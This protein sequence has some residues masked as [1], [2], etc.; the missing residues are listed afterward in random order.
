V[1][2]TQFHSLVLKLG[3][4]TIPETVHAL[5]GL[6]AKYDATHP[7]DGVFLSQYLNDLYADIERQ[8]TIFSAFSGVAIAIAALGLLGL[9]ISTAERRTKEIGLRKVLGAKRLDILQFL[10]WQFARPVLW[11]NFLAWPCAYFVL[12]RWLEGFAYHIDQGPLLFILAGALALL[13][14]FL[15]VVGH[16]L[17]VARAKPVDALRYE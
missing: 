12:Q 5:E 17:A 1:D 6:W 10:A 15:T 3:G 7:F 13:I 16:A 14:A 11:A 2:P 9:A 4:G 8:S